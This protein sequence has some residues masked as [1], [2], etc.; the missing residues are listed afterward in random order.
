MR[1]AIDRVVRPNP[2][3]ATRGA[4]GV[5]GVVTVGWCV[6]AIVTV[7]ACGD[8]G[9]VTATGALAVEVADVSGDAAGSASPSTSPSTGATDPNSNDA[10][11]ATCPLEVELLASLATAYRS[12]FGV[13]A[14]S[15]SD[16]A[17]RGL[18]E[19]GLPGARIDADGSVH[20]DP[21]DMCVADSALVEVPGL[22]PTC[23]EEL[24]RLTV[25][26]AVGLVFDDRTDPVAR[27]SAL[28]VHHGPYTRYAWVDGDPVALTDECPDAEQLQAASQS[29]DTCD[30]E[31]KTLET[32]IEV[33]YAQNLVPPMDE[34]S[35]VDEGYL[36]T[37]VRGYDLGIDSVSGAVVAVA[38]PGGPCDI[39]G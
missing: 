18:V 14:T 29:E 28:G 33:Y 25:D 36:R 23:A 4:R 27:A 3:A 20:P 26:V 15:E 13:A 5:R 11:P 17:T 30:V 6:A 10:A 7:T 32:V 37:Q 8:E 16:F 34:Q 2:L 35:M 19:I 21:A 1:H 31:R 38:A 22:P 12:E 9:S 39:G 24:D